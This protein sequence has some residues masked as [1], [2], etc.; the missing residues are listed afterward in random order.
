M[1]YDL[2]IIGLGPAGIAAAVY[3]KR[4][5]LNVLC[6]EKVMPGGYINYINSISNYIGIPT[7]S[8][9]DLAFNLFKQLKENEIEYKI[10][11]VEKVNI[12]DE[13]KILT[14]NKG[15]YVA[16]NIIVATG[17]RPK[18]LNLENEAQLLGKGISTC[19]LC[20]GNLFKDKDVAVIGGGDSAFSEAIY[21]SNICKSV[22]IINRS[23]K[24]RA[25]KELVD[26]VKG[27]NNIKIINNAIVTSINATDDKLESITLNDIDRLSVDGMFTYIG[28][29]PATEFMKDLDIL[30]ENGFMLVNDSYE[31][32]ISGIYGVGDVIKKNIY[33]IC[34]AINDG[35][36]A[37]MS[38][39]DKR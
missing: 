11:Y 16:K 30:D 8:G 39:I 21:L 22:Y 37:T 29:S 33:Q 18:R 24:Y 9:P 4:A 26:K 23:D 34:T 19:A 7:I 2:I 15:E 20:D 38:I 10:E 31:S 1:V 36:V 13:Q 6:L 35:I 28:S 27:I 25:I 17:K 12:K 14:T 5:G 32:K 3:A